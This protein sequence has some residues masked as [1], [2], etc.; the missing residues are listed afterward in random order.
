MKMTNGIDLWKKQLTD[1]LKGKKVTII[2]HDNIDVDSALSGILLSKLLHFLNIEN[3][4]QILEEVKEDEIYVIVKELIGIDLKKWQGKEEENRNLF[5][6]D[7]YETSHKGNVLGIIDHH[8]TKQEKSYDFMYVKNSCATAYMIYEIMKAVN[9]PITK[10]EAKMILVAMMI[11]TISFRSSKTV[12]EEVKQAKTLAKEYKLDYNYLEKQGL[13]LT[14]VDTLNTQQ[15]I[16]NGQKW[17]NYSG[18]KVGSAYLQLYGMPAKEKVDKWLTNIK[19]NLKETNSNMLVLIIFE[20]KSNM[21]YE[22][23]IMSDSIKEI[24]SKGILSRGKNIMPIIEERYLENMDTEEKLEML[25]KKLTKNKKTIATMESCTGGG[26]ASEITNISGASEILKKSYVTYCNEA[27]IEL[28][29]PKEVIEK[30]TVYSAETAIAMATA[31]S[32][33]AQSN[34]GI[35]IT[36]QLGRID[37]QNPSGEVGNVWYAINNEGE[38]TV[39]K[40]KVE[41]MPRKEQKAVVIREIIETLYSKI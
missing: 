40:L 9:F 30:H 26:L 28:G 2:G 39:H 37:P 11:D 20:T 41:D 27:K 34:I 6:V 12:K 15:I 16:S 36:G 23:Q 10:M 38:I 25:V 19:T 14:P 33:K 13:C 8:P 3:E 17:Y 1:T 32:K 5:L 7:H 21:T 35:G 22:Y 18:S 31:V 29:V 24:V 4:F